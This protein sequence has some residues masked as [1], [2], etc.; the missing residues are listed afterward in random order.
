MQH[1]CMHW[2]SVYACLAAYSNACR[3][4]R[5]RRRRHIHLRVHEHVPTNVYTFLPANKA[6][7]NARNRIHAIGDYL[8]IRRAKQIG[9]SEE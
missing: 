6:T 2:R 7:L 8:L 1:G 5:L 9:S 4:R 3:R